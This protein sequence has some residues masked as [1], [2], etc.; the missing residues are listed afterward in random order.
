MFV[1][2]ARPIPALI[3]DVEV[4]CRWPP[5]SRLIAVGRCH[6]ICMRFYLFCRRPRFERGGNLTMI[7]WKFAFPSFFCGFKLTFFPPE[8]SRPTWNL[9]VLALCFYFIA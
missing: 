4:N 5:F 9:F 8:T 1:S 6:L 2:K 3:K 7:E